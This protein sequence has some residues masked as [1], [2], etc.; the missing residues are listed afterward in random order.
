[1]K[2]K[3]EIKSKIEQLVKDHDHLLKGGRATIQINAPRALMQLD[4]M[5][6]IGTLYWV[7]GEKMPQFELDTKP[8]NT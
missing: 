4:V 6:R 5:A 8:L 1:M 3:A 7:I 2:S